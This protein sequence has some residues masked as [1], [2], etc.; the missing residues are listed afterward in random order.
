[1]YNSLKDLLF[2]V[3]QDGVVC[4]ETSNDDLVVAEEIHG[5]GFFSN[6]LDATADSMEPTDDGSLQ[7]PLL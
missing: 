1:M 2:D 5:L 6:V 3:E 7:E 4:L